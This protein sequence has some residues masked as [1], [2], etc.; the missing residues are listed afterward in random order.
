[1]KIMNNT[2]GHRS[3]IFLVGFMGSG[4]TF[5]GERLA[6]TLFYDF[7][8]TDALLEK[9]TRQTIA[10]I[11]EKNGENNF[12]ELEH[13]ILSELKEKKGCI[14]STGGGVPCF[15]G[16]MEIMNAHGITVYLKVHPDII[17]KR[18]SEQRSHRPLLKIFKDDTELLVFVKNKIAER[19]KFYEQ[20]QFIIDADGNAEEIIKKIVSLSG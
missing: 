2:E 3:S 15:Y 12:R 5:I 8:D 10:E 4:K 13:A 18:I 7:I 20:A 19:E 6:E 14:I 16:N 11:F 17:V 1:M 9:K